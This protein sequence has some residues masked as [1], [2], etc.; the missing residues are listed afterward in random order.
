MGTEV[1]EIDIPLKQSLLKPIHG[2][3]FWVLYDHPR[4]KEIIISGFEGVG[5]TEA[6]TQEFLNED[7]FADLD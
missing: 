4:N 7:P 5:I 2:R 3:G 6:V 1:Y